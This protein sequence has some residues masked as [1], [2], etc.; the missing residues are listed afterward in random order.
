MEATPA[1]VP[2]Y[3]VGMLRLA[4]LGVFGFLI[5]QA[6]GLLVAMFGRAKHT[7][8]FRSLGPFVA[9]AV[10]FAI[11]SSYWSHESARLTS[12]GGV[13]VWHVRHNGAGH[14]L[15]GNSLQS[16]GLSRRATTFL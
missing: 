12:D 6:A 11:A 7:L 1:T 16:W 14:H 9:A 4:A 10:Y 2:D 8:L 3:L 15:W 5:P 13:L